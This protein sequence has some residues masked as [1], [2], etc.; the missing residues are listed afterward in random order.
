MPAY[1]QISGHLGQDVE[2]RFTNSGTPVANVSLA[3]N[4][5][6]KDAGGEKVSIADW[7]RVTV[8]GRNAE[9]LAQYAKKGSGLAFNGRLQTDSYLDREG[10]ERATT[11]LIADSFEFMS[12]AKRDEGGGARPKADT[13]HEKVSADELEEIPF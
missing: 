9:V 4:R 8:F 12:R 1:A 6:K 7:F 5:F 2:L 11:F 10:V 13:R 3:S